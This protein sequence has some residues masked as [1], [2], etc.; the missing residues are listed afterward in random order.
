[1]ASRTRRPTWRDRG[2]RPPRTVSAFLAS[3]LFLSS[4]AP[5]CGY[6][7][8]SALPSN[9]KSI[10]IPVFGNN[11]VEFGIADDVTQALVNGFLNDRHL[12]IVQ[13]RDADSVLRGTVL[14]YKNQ[15]FG[16]TSQ[17][18]ATEYEVVLTVQIAFRDVGRNRDLWKEDALTVRST[19]NVVAVGAEAAKTEAD[20]RRDA[21]QKLADLVVSRTVQG[22]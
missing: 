9:L 13:E 11:T 10:A 21:V 17:E 2:R 19:Y 3:L 4:L 12:K 14:A 22:W 16:Y 18:R 20:G 8:R 5:G 6:T 15:V 7:L 1:M